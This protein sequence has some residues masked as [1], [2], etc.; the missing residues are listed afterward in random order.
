MMAMVSSGFIRAKCPW[1]SMHGNFDRS[2]R[3]FGTLSIGCGLNW[4][5]SNAWFSVALSAGCAIGEARAT[6]AK[7]GKTIRL[8][9][10]VKR[11]EFMTVMGCVGYRTKPVFSGSYFQSGASAG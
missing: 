11:D 9:K 8:A 6:A 5:R 1:K 4:P 7:P 2:I 10:R 3:F